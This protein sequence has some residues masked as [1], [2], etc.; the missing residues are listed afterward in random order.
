MNPGEIILG[1]SLI[2][3]MPLALIAG[4]ISFVSPCVLPL[5]PGYLGYIS[6]VADGGAKK[7][8]II[9][10][11]VLFVLG[12]T[13]VFVSF[14]A[15]F[16]GLGALIYINNLIWVQQVLGVLI[17][18]MGFVLVGQF[19][20]LQRTFKTGIK[21]RV[22]LIGAPLLGVAFGLGWTP[23]IGPT[24][25]AVLT[26]ASDAGSPGRGA[27][28]AF[29]YSLGIGIPFIAIAAGFGWA[30]RS[31]GFVKKHIRTFNIAGGVILIA[32][33]IALATGVWVGFAT[34]LQ[35]VFGVFVPAL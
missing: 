3:A 6:G 12:F 21:P 25:A 8:K 19:S 27:L 1:G 18:L 14:G 16:G 22:G 15:L 24:L 35:G 31:V 10:G 34:W 7:S 29:L 9:L 32:L 20:F 30:T 17:I 5:I 4:I 33:G 26:L 23:C 28:L 11:S 13:A 2:A